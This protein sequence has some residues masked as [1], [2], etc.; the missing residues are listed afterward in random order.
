MPLL[1]IVSDP[2]MRG[3]KE[4]RAYL[5]KLRSLLLFAGV[6]D[7]KMQEGSLRCD[8]N[9]SVRPKGETKLGTRVEIK[10]LNSF[11]SLGKSH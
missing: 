9:V 1:E 4:A 10:N 7:C 5:E 3:A 11:R 2:D 8:A 6:S